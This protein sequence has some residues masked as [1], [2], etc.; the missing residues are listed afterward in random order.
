MGLAFFADESGVFNL[1]QVP[2]YTSLD[3][4]GGIAQPVAANRAGPSTAV[5]SS[6]AAGAGPPVFKS[7]VATKNISAAHNIKVGHDLAMY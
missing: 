3:V 7:V 5:A 4:E 6:T 2:S 1:D